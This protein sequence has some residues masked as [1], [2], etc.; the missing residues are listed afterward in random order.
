MSYQGYNFLNY[1]LNEITFTLWK[2]WGQTWPQKGS[3]GTKLHSGSTMT[4][5]SVNLTR[6]MTQS[7]VNLTPLFV[8]SLQKANQILPGS[9][10]DP[11]LSMDPF[12]SHAD[13]GVLR[14]YRAYTVKTKALK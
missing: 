1:T 7:W 12:L 5:K 10:F 14:V 2:H 3:I 8:K 6:N 4:R 11:E 13:P 9:L